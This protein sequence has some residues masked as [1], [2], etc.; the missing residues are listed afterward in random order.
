MSRLPCAFTAGSR[1]TRHSCR[2]CLRFWNAAYPGS[3]HE[4]Q[5]ERCRHQS[6][7]RSVIADSDHPGFGHSAEGDPSRRHDR[8]AVTPSRRHVVP[9]SR[10]LSRHAV[11]PSRRPV[12]PSVTFVTALIPSR[13]SRPFRPS[14]SSRSSR[15]HGL[16]ARHAR[17]AVMGKARYPAKSGTPSKIPLV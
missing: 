10:L 8:H 15:R 5:A 4:V 7:E 3:L 17:H 6:I 1:I 2:S 16:S 9:S 14:R 13:P 11:T 12:V